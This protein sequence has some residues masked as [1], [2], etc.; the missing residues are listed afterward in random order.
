MRNFGLEA[1]TWT[2]RTGSIES[3]QDASVRLTEEN[4]SR[5]FEANPTSDK[6]DFVRSLQTAH[7]RAAFL[8]SQTTA[9]RF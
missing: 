3:A 2:G 8:H 7:H 9:Q 5:S 1:E 4:E 6:V